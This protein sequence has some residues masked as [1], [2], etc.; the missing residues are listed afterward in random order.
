[1]EKATEET[2]LSRDEAKY[3]PNFLKICSLKQFSQKAKQ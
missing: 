1:M 3:N 2:M